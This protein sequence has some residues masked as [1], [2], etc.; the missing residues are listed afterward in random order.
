[1][2]FLSRY[3]GTDQ[4]DLG[5]GYNVTIKRFLAGD[6]LEKAEAVRVRAVANA[7]TDGMDKTVKI[8]TTQDVA[9][10]TEA[11]L[12]GAIVAWN[13]TDEYDVLLPLEPL[14]KKINSIRLLPAEA[15]TALR[16]KIEENTNSTVRSTEDQKIFRAAGDL[17]TEG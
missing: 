10:Y 16:D 2:G 6:V 13:L 4:V 14:E 7:T 15:R 1:M 3:S 12:V 9:A 11:L 8:E 17:G 5:E